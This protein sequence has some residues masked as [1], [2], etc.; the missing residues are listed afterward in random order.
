MNGAQHEQ[1]TTNETNKTQTKYKQNKDYRTKQ[2]HILTKQQ[3]THNSTF[4]NSV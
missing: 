2:T 4:K 3:R 1:H